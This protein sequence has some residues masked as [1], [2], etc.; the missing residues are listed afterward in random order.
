MAEK[1]NKYCL[2][3]NSVNSYKFRTLTSGIGLSRYLK[4]PIILYNHN[5]NI[6]SVG[7]MA[8]LIENE[9]LVGEPEWDLEDEMGKELSRKYEKGFMNGF[10]VSLEPVEFSDSEELRLPG[11]ERLT[12]TRSELIEISATNI[13]SNANAVRLS[14][15]QENNIEKFKIFNMKK[16]ALTLGLAENADENT[17]NV[18]LSAILDEN[19]NLN[20][21]K[22]KLEG[23]FNALKLKLQEKEDAELNA[24][25][26]NPQKKLTAAQKESYK[27]LAKSDRELVI[28]LVNELPDYQ[29]LS[30]I[31]NGDK[32]EDD[33]LKLSFDELHKK[34]SVFLS[35]LK[36]K[37]PE[38]YKEKYKL[39][40]GV[41]PK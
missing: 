18:K 24:V 35:E 27:K 28:K 12:L 34:H 2:S 17:I 23:D 38:V 14:N 8:V 37:Q 41:E 11:Q 1:K 26:D 30:K 21:E 4:N 6:M 19:K 3:D 31:P 29:S 25:L 9:K 32:N 22:V 20:A 13:P 15:N 7:K 16:I 36:V 5:G 40:Y 33:R 10:S 39:Q